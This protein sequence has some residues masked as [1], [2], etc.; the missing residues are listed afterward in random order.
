MDL[1]DRIRNN[2]G[3]LGQWSEIAEGYWIFPK[4]GGE[5]SRPNGV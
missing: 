2:P 5:L 3:P 1:F 4:L